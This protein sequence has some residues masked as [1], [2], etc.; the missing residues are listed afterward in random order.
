MEAKISYERLLSLV[1]LAEI[2]NQQNDFDE[3]LRLITHKVATLLNSDSS[4]I[5]IVN[6]L[7]H[8]TIKT[9]IKEENPK[10]QKQYQFIH[11]IISGWVTNNKLPFLSANL[12]DDE[13][14]SSN[15]FANTPFK[16]KYMHSIKI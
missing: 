1:E 11:A 5:M 2:Q 16:F 10:I 3:V 8:N 7:T 15:I 13:R 6:P 14:F 4:L 12:K 9:I